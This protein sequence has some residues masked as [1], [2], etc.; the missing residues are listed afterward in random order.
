MNETDATHRRSVGEVEDD[1]PR[2]DLDL[3]LPDGGKVQFTVSV[4]PAPEHKGAR[5]TVTEHCS[6]E[7]D[8]HQAKVEIETPADIVRR[9]YFY[10][11]D[12]HEV[13]HDFIYTGKVQADLR[14]YRLNITSRQALETGAAAVHDVIEIPV[15]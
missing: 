11:A 14:Q 7:T 1:K 5:I 6:R 13:R 9:Q 4:D 3:S 12:K 2:P 15:N 10:S 8:L